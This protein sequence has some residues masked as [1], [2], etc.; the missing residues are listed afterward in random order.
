MLFARVATVLV[1]SLAASDAPAQIFYRWTDENGRVQ[2]SDT[3]PPAGARNL[4][5]RAPASAAAVPPNVPN[6][7]YV[8]QL[9]RKTAPVTLYSAPNCEPCDKARDLLEARGVPFT[10]VSVV[11][12]KRAEELMRTVG[13]NAVP[14]IV[15]G[16]AVQQGFEEATYHRILDAAGYPKTGVVRRRTQ[17]Q[18]RSGAPDAEAP[19]AA[20]ERPSGPYAPGA[21]RSQKK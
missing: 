14:S 6:E 16:S 18:P 3:P 13:A 12:E 20:E 11:S 8:L 17:E 10:E 4:E 15:V 2:I 9:A 1:V 21:K 5:K 19:A 7:P